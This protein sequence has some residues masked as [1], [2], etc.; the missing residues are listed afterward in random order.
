[1]R[2][3]SHSLAKDELIDN[4]TLAMTESIEQATNEA[5]ASAEMLNETALHW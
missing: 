2:R 4:S 1:M 5:A 3:Y